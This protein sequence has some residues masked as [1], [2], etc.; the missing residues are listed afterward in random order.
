MKKVVL[1]TGASKGIGKALAEKMLNENFFVIGTSR[2]RKIKNFEH[3]NFYSLRLD[4]SNTESIEKAHKEIFKNFKQIDLLIN[5]AG[6]GP[7]LDTYIPEK[8]SFNLTFDVNVAGT[9]FFTEPLIEL[10]KERGIF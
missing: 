8:E 5:N 2:N 4:L 7:D 9:V 3:Q 1:I 10:I 6:I